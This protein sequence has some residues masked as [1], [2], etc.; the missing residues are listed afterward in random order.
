MLPDKLV[1]KYES[2]AQGAFKIKFSN[3]GKYMAA[4][5]TLANNKT[6]VKIFDC[7]DGHLQL[8]LR[9][10]NDLIHDICW[11]FDDRFLVTASADGS[12]RIW[13]LTDK[14]TENSDRFNYQ[15][16][17]RLFFIAEIY[18]PSFVYGA[19]IHPR[20]REEGF[21]YIATACYDQKI[22]I[23]EV[24]VDDLEFPSYTCK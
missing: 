16:N 19:K 13:N 4:A 23:W 9:G 11:S 3:S 10:H 12:V 17:D 15:D 21:I 8:I 6:L 18:H 2:E 14:E 24:T 1:W 20:V 22:R 7:E 5:C